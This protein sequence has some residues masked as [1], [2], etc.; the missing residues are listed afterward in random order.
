MAALVAYAPNL[1][2]VEICQSLTVTGSE[3]VAPEL[4][5]HLRGQ[6]AFHQQ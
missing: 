4:E 3:Y 1:K 6:L 2:D 5:G